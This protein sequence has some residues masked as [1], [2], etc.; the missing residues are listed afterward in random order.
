MYETVKVSIHNFIMTITLHRPEKLNAYSLQMH[1][2]LLDCFNQADEDDD[3]RV[4]II[5]G[6][7]RAYCAGAD[8]E[9]GADTFKS[10]V[11]MDEF[12]DKAGI[13]A[14]RIFEL[15]K[16]IIAAI[17]GAA[18]G[19]GVTMTLPMDIRIAS[20]NAKMGFVFT[21]RGITQEAC[22]SWFLPRI[23]GINQAL[24]WVSTGRIFSSQ[25]ALGKGLVSRVVPRQELLHTAQQLAMEIVDNTS[26]VSVAI[27][28]Q[29]LWKMLAAEHPMRA[30]LLE[31]KY[32]YCTGRSEDAKEG[33]NSFLE[34]RKP[35]FPLKVSK[36][37]PSFFNEDN[38]LI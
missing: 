34:K 20:D 25:E 4:I 15:K 16:P 35:N 17:N 12:R 24:E 38:E 11:P 26:A 32:L 36:D 10:D 13:L 3:V 31:S 29:L 2:E 5:T 6:K 9:N 27:N 28:K 22:S 33:V 14:L 21:R 23:V 7:G 8:L 37:M 1:D 19:I 18:I 30:H